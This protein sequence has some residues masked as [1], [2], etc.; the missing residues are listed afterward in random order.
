MI[1]IAAP[2]KDIDKLLESK[3][4]IVFWKELPYALKKYAGTSSYNFNNSDNKIYLC[5][6]NMIV[7]VGVIS[8]IYN[9]HFYEKNSVGLQIF[10]SR[11]ACVEEI[12]KKWCGNQ[13]IEYPSCSWIE[14][15]EFYDYLHNLGYFSANYGIKL[16]NIRKYKVT[17]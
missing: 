16:E 17:R 7:A 9:L 3:T 15:P 5:D 2:R 6:N 4:T 14:N 8:N 11:H 12:Y 10:K 1:V 13:N